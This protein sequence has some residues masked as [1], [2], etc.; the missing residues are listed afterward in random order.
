[1]VGGF[2]RQG[3]N[4]LLEGRGLLG[5]IKHVSRILSSHGKDIVV[6]CDNMSLVLAISK[7]RCKDVH[8]LSCSEGSP[9]YVLQRSFV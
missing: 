9:L 3:E 6:L 4:I 5:T 8:L 1:M 2:Q 7:G